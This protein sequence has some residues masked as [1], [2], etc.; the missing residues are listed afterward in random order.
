M[1]TVNIFIP[2]DQQKT[3]SVESPHEQVQAMISQTPTISEQNEIQSDQVFG[4][5]EKSGKTNEEKE[6]SPYSSA[7]EKLPLAEPHKQ[8]LKS[9]L[10]RDSIE[11]VKH[12]GRLR[13]GTEL[14]LQKKD[15]NVEVL[16][17]CV[18]DLDPITYPGQ[19][20]PLNELRHAWSISGVF[21]ILVD[22]ITLA[23]L[24]TQRA[25]VPLQTSALE[26]SPDQQRDTEKAWY[27]GNKDKEREGPYSFK[28]VRKGHCHM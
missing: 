14:Y 7:I 8:M 22:M 21:R 23:H 26:A 4:K 10:Y 16:V 6:E 3:R 25:Y 18:M 5:T 1:N 27:Y 19:P 15:T 24:H 9:R 20:S 17:T 11:I 13:T 12:F 2:T 28:E